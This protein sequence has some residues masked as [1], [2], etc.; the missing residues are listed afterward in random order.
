[1]RT[2]T[3]GAATRDG[4]SSRRWQYRG[5]ND[6]RRIAGV[7]SQF[8]GQTTTYFFYNFPDKFEARDLWHSFQMYGKVVDV[9]VLQKRDKRGK[10]FGF[11]RFSGVQNAEW[12]AKRLSGIWIG[13]YKM[14]VKVADKEQRMGREGKTVRDG[15]A[16]TAIRREDRLVQP[17]KS[18]VQVVAGPART[19]RT[20]AIEQIEEKEETQ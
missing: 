2:G 13:S 18:Y 5:D 14:I 3:R 19:T 11:V 12:M 17:G 15:K 8:L 16:G 10:R 4:G 6:R 1:M 7:D 20:V 9:F